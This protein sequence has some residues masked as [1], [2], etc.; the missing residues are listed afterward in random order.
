MFGVSGPV[1]IAENMVGAA[2]Y[3]LVSLAV[4]YVP[5]PSTVPFLTGRIGFLFAYHSLSRC[6]IGSGWT[7]RARWR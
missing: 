1:V 6:K 5:L 7:R 2:M 3:E 4:H